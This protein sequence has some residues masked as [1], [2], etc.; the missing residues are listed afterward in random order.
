MTPAYPTILLDLD[1]TVIDSVAL[2]RE[3]HRHAV[4][5]VLGEDWEDERLVRNVGR[6]LME[7]M[8]AFS[9]AHAAELYTVYRTWNHANTAALL[10]AYAG[11][12]T[13]LADLRAAGALLGIVTSKSRDAVDL[14]FASMPI[15][16]LF[17]VVISADDSDRHKPH[18]DPL[19]AALARLGRGSEGA[20]YVGDAPFDIRA[21]RA[22]GV[23]T[24]AVTWGFFDEGVLNDEGPDATARSVAE[25]RDILLGPVPRPA[26]PP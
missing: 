7:Q 2:I 21:G 1:G 15:E 19:L 17:D 6:P 26:P 8:E 11:M 14:A 22:A 5:A 9:P 4:R 24:V 10:A 3:S 13:L 16:D 18:P 20:C 12:E 23:A 25:L